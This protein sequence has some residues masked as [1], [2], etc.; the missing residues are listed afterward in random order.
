MHEMF[1]LAELS[2]REARAPAVVSVDDG[3]VVPGLGGSTEVVW[4]D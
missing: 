1:E 2:R 4:C 3:G